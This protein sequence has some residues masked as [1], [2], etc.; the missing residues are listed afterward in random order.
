MAVCLC[1]GKCQRDMD[2]LIPAVK[3]I[4]IDPIFVFLLFY[5]EHGVLHV[6]D[7]SC[8]SYAEILNDIEPRHIVK[9]F[10]CLIG[11]ANA[12]AVNVIVWKRCASSLMRGMTRSH[13][14]R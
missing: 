3:E 12:V 11:D 9:L 5:D 8:G 7:Q 13:R 10:L 4:R 14:R 1:A 6:G 2:C